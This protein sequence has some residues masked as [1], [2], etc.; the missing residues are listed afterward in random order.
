LAE[1]SSL[2]QR[3]EE[4]AQNDGLATENLPDSHQS[5]LAKVRLGMASSLFISLRTK[6]PPTANHSLRVALGVSSWAAVKELPDDQRDSVEIAA[7]LHDVGKIGVPDSVLA[8]PG[9]LSADELL[10]MERS[11]LIGYEILSGC[12][13]ATP[14][15]E[16]ML[17]AGAWYDGS[18]HGYDRSGSD[19]PLGSRMIGIVDAFDA[20]TS[21]HVYRAALS[22]ERA[23]A[24]LCE[25]AGTQFDPVLV[26]EF[27]EFITRDSAKYQGQV[28]RR[29]LRE[30]SPEK[31][32]SHWTCRG[33]LLA[34]SG[35]HTGSSFHESLVDTLRDG[36]MFVDS[37]ST[38]VHWNRSAEQLTGIEP[39][40]VLQRQ[41]TPGLV[42]LRDERGR[43]VND[44]DCPVGEVLSTGRGVARRYS[45]A[46]RRAERVTVDLH[47]S[48]VLDDT[49]VARGATVVMHDVSSQSSLEARVQALNE[50]AA[51]DPLTKTA[52]RAEFTRVF[53]DFVDS[54]LKQGRPCSLII[55]DIDYF[56]K[57]NDTFGHQAGDEAL[58]LFASILQRYARSGDWVVRYGGEE[59]VVLCSECDNAAATRRAEEIRR[60]VAETAMPTLENRCITASFGVTEIQGGDTPKTFFNR[61][62]RALLQAKEAGRNLVVQ[63]GTGIGTDSKSSE[64]GGWFRWFRTQAGETLLERTL[65]TGVPLKVTV[66][67]LRG[68]VSD[69]HAQLGK[70]NDNRVGLTID[71]HFIPLVRRSTDRAVPFQVDLHFEEKTLAVEGRGNQAALRTLIHVCIR[72]KRQRDRRQREA[73]ERAR[74][75]LISLKSYLIAQDLSA[76]DKPDLPESTSGEPAAATRRRWPWSNK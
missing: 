59:F 63:L 61:A 13:A 40:T 73:V 20:M 23:V 75:I 70:I 42:Q 67:K 48:P 36:V 69:H 57:I 18:K 50:R 21:E 46:S 51:R 26:R 12:C 5:Q 54:H 14:I 64:P 34:G 62:D 25:F 74:Q 37:Q 35:L 31:S 66:E 27:C 55:C 52:N 65:V 56:K 1:L 16:N 6:H 60:R 47:I 15:V 24:E 41:W 68:F 9:K 53:P 32:D 22:R 43:L 30:L 28:A 10:A 49:G 7:L 33:P 58:V 2:L 39:T 44:P 17:Y 72:P 11:R 29:W 76:A 8:K 4:A 45:M 38:V 19:L 3:L 71:S